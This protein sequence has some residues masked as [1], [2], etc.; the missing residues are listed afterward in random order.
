MKN[1]AKDKMPVRACARPRRL[2]HTQRGMGLIE[3]MVVI[4]ISM[5]MMAGLLS[6]VY[7]TR[8]NFTAQAQLAQLQD[9]ER[10]AM[11]IITNVVQ[12]GGYFSNP[13]NQTVSAAFPPLT[14]TSGS[15]TATFA[16]RQSISGTGANANNDQIWVRY[17]TGGADDVMDCNGQTQTVSTTYVNYLYVN[18][19]MLWCQAFWNGTAQTAQPL[20][21]GVSRMNVLYGVNT[22]GTSPAAADT[23]MTATQ[24]AAGPYWNS[25]VS[26]QVIL[27]FTPN[28]ISTYKGT[29]G[30]NIFSGWTPSI[31][32]TI[33]LLNRV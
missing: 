3:M 9:S 24:V 31:T 12:S 26:A 20:V 14:V 32:R 29:A 8:Q 21:A 19:G 27:T 17:T 5:F 30:A 18:N 4:L 25:V 6:M 28:A 16:V 15:N 33:D 11:N 23:Y 1:P 13:G 22:A 7:G 2:P 10:L